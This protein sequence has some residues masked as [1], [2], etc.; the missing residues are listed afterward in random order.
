MR[1][2]E[3]GGLEPVHRFFGQ[4]LMPASVDSPEPTIVSSC[5]D[6]SCNVETLTMGRFVS[7]SDGPVVTRDLHLVRLLSR[8]RPSDYNQK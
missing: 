5:K 1:E 2:V 8:D 7:S 6:S 4:I 3:T